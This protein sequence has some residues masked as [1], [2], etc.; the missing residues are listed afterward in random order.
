MLRSFMFMPILAI[1]LAVPAT[2]QQT[3]DQNAWQAGESVVQAHSRA[4]QTKD[5]AAIADLYT[6]DAILVTTN[7]PLFGRVAI[8][9]F[10]EKVFKVSTAE[11]AKLDQVIMIGDAVRWRTGSWS[12]VF[13]SPHG[14]M[15]VKGFW[16]TTDV[17]AGNTWKIRMETDNV[18]MP[19]P[20][21]E[22]KE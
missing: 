14:P 18:T 3:S 2:A 19:P 11:P 16:A 13:Q 10:F 1:G 12:A 5:A 7:G 4:S 20:S 22:P 21:S 15:P 6:E 17:R 8:E 9:K